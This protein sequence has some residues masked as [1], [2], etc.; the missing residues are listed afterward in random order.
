MKDHEFYKKYTNTPLEKRFSILDKIHE[1]N[2]TLIC[3]G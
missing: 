1:G 2:L 3:Y